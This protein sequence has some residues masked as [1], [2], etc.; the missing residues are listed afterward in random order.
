MKDYLDKQSQLEDKKMHEKKSVQLVMD[1]TAK[2][3]MTK[4]H[5]KFMKQHN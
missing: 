4:N 3:K 5:D 1:K 2:D